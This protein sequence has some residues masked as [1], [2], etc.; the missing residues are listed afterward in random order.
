MELMRICSLDFGGST[1]D[2]LQWHDGQIQ[3][4]D[5]YERSAFASVDLE[6]LV[7][8]AQLS[9]SDF[10]QIRIT[11]GKSHLYVERFRGVP[12]VRVDEIE[13]IGRGGAWLLRSLFPDEENCLT[14][15]M[16]TGTCMVA[17]RDQNF[18]HVGGTGVGGGTFLSLCRFLLQEQDP[19][20]LVQLFNEG[21]RRKVDLSVGELVGRDIG[22]INAQV[23]A[24]NL[25]KLAY[26]SEIEFTRADLA[27]GIVNLIGQTIATAAIF[28]AKAHQL[29]Q[30]LLTGKL[31]RI[32]PMVEIIRDVGQLYGCRIGVPPQGEFVSAIGAGVTKT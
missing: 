13:A 7:D 11:G 29:P 6:T 2:V 14:V 31:T 30:I 28:A 20:V 19:A 5:S 8:Y 24:S 3:R 32:Q 27:G 22:R 12:V 21:D 10:D 25:G 26:G 17:V 18:E 4:I 16:G 9:V 15:S 1:L 23:T